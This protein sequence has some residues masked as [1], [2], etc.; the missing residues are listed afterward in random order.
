M[1]GTPFTM[2][3]FRAL[4]SNGAPLS[5]G[6][7][8]TYQAGTSTPLATY[9]NSTLATPNSNPVV[10]DSTG[11]ANVWLSSA[12]GSYK[13]VLENASAVIQWTV[14]NFPA[15]GSGGG[16]SSAPQLTAPG[17]RLTL[18]SGTPVTTNDVTGATTIYY[19]PHNHD[20]VPL[21]DGS[22]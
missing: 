14:D 13:L 16:S 12:L 6:L 11:S 8:Y 1:S 17:G 2:G 18:T 5:G 3:L 20:Q 15:S 19:V 4:D 7:L 22:A 9:T 10:L 21:Y